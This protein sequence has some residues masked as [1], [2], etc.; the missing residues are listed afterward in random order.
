MR[1]FNGTGDTQFFRG[2]VL[3][4]YLINPPDA[5]SG[6]IAVANPRLEECYD[7]IFLVGEVPPSPDDWSSGLRISIGF[8]QVAHFL[9][10]SDVDEY[11]EKTSSM[12]GKAGGSF[13]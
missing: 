2:K 6:G 4:V 13:Q 7:R 11:I 5:F 3:I 1:Q 10:F 8:D 12:R 9:E